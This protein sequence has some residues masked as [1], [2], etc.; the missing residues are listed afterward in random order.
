MKVEL[1]QQQCSDGQISTSF[2]TLPRHFGDCKGFEKPS[3]TIDKA[4]P[5]FLKISKKKKVS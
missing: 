3:G 2:L 4:I 5:F 1:V